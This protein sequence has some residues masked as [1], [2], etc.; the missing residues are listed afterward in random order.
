MRIDSYLLEGSIHRV[1][2]ISSCILIIH[3]LYDLTPCISMLYIPTIIIAMCLIS[4]VILM[5]TT[6][7]IEIFFHFCIFYRFFDKPHILS[8]EHIMEF[9]IMFSPESCES[10]DSCLYG[11]SF[12]FLSMSIIF[13]ILDPLIHIRDITWRYLFECFSECMTIDIIID[14]RTEK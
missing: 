2:S 7:M 13:E 4:A 3:R 10:I 14:T 8:L 1:Q 11:I 12:S 5:N 6:Q 9:A